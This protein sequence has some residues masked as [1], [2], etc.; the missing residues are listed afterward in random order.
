MTIYLPELDSST[1]QFPHP[2]NALSEPNG[3]LAMGGDLSPKRLQTAY[4]EGIFPWFSEGEPLLWWSPT[5]RGV[6]HPH[7]FMPSKSL[8]KFFRKSG[9]TVTINKAC[10]D[11][12][13]HCASCRGP[14][15]TWITEEMISAYQR[16]HTLGICH[17]VEVWSNGKLVGGFY[18]VE[19]GTVFCGES[20]F[21]LADNASKI[22]L[23]QFCR[24]FSEL[25]GT[26]IDCQM[27]NPHLESLGA[28]T[29]ERS[30]FLDH[31]YQ[32]RDIILPIK[33]YLSHVLPIAQA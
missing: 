1:Y 4:R 11:V 7:T 18:G 5:P 16:L 26:L 14:E 32:Q 31:L 33:T 17:S 23:W 12:I 6:F 27:M 25:G 2:S 21:S 9:Y 28:E 20:M 19:I 8:K 10:H 29:F 13:R 15:Q 22:A 30:L 3:L 24:Y